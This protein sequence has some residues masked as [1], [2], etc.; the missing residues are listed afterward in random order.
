MN[1]ERICD[2]ASEELNQKFDIVYREGNEWKGPELTGW[3]MYTCQ[4]VYVNINY[5]PFCGGL[6]TIKKSK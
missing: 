6:L 2:C 4:A 3:S 5:C 1:I